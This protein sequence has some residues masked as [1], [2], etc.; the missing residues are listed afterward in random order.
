MNFQNEEH[1]GWHEPKP[2][3]TD[4]QF[5]ITVLIAAF[6]FI[7]LLIAKYHEQN[8]KENEDEGQ[9]AFKCVHN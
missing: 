7:L 1:D 2:I 9:S 5:V 3:I 6:I 4:R 8:K